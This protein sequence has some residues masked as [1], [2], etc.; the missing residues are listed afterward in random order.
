M[1]SRGISLKRTFSVFY[2]IGVLF[3]EVHFTENQPELDQWFHSYE[4]LKGSQNNRENTR[5]HSF[6][7]LYLTINAP[8][9]RLILL[10]DLNTYAQTYFLI[11]QQLTPSPSCYIKM[12][13]SSELWCCKWTGQSHSLP[14]ARSSTIWFTM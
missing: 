2:L 5:M 6:F 4:H 1:R 12:L 10:V 9:F 11:M 3:G 13:K 8:N 14:L 7:W